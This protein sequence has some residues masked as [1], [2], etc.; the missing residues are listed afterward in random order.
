MWGAAAGHGFPVSRKLF[1]IPSIGG[2]AGQAPQ[3]PTLL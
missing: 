3:E 1:A 2:V